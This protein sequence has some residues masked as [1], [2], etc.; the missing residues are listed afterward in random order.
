MENNLDPFWF[1]LEGEK[2]FLLS[3]PSA[4]RSIIDCPLCEHSADPFLA[5]AATA[6]EAAATNR[7][8]LLNAM[9]LVRIRF[10]PRRSHFFPASIL[11]K[12]LRNPYY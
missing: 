11:R 12:F 9:H 1:V 4:A 3:W 7:H 5:I 2:L 8:W 10:P 6:A